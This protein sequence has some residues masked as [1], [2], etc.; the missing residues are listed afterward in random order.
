MSKKKKSFQE[1]VADW[2][3]KHPV[4]EE[5]VDAILEKR[6]PKRMGEFFKNCSGS[7]DMN[8][9]PDD[10]FKQEVHNKK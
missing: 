8:D 3:T 2:E 10:Y 6:S 7:L 9:F 1:R 5:D 4:S